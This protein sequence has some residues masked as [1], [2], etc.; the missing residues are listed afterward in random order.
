[1]ENSSFGRLVGVLAAPRRTFAAIAQRPT[2]LVAMVVLLAI[3]T[4]AVFA[5]YSRID[6]AEA[7]RSQLEARGT[8]VSPEQLEQMID[9]GE[10]FWWIQPLVFGLIFGPIAYL[11]TAAAFLLLLRLSGGELS[12]EQSLST[13]LHAFMPQAVAGLLAIPVVLARAEIDPQEMQTGGLLASH[14]GVFAPE[15]ASPV[16]ASLLSS[17]DVFSLWTIVLL[18][19]GYGLVARVSRTAAT[20]VTLVLWA[21]YVL[22]FKVGMVAAFT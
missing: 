2:V 16:L 5:A 1:M 17:I 9:V 12:F 15:D 19:L 3:G 21:L 20:V 11:L 13:S 10:R 4:A 8:E 14:L 22:I 7:T 18:V 6:I